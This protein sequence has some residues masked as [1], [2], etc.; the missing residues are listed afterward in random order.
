MN[1]NNEIG[2]KGMMYLC[3]ALLDNTGLTTLIAWNNKITQAASPGLARALVIHLTLFYIFKA[4]FY[5]I[6]NF[7]G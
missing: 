4:I 7:S 1:R 6:L 5:I 3:D 2:D